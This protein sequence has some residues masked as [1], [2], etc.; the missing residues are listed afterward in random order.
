MFEI[1]INS[2]FSEVYDN[3]KNELDKVDWKVC[4]QL[5]PSIDLIRVY[6]RMVVW[7]K[8][9]IFFIYK[10]GLFLLNAA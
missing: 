7:L 10:R 5:R 4:M 9:L 6:Y 8:E 1:I 2:T 3:R